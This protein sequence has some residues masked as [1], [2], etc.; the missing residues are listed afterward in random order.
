MLFGSDGNLKALRKDLKAV[1][2]NLEQVRL[3]EKQYEKIKRQYPQQKQ[4]YEKTRQ[5]LEDLEQT[6]Q[7]MEQNAIHGDTDKYKEMGKELKKY[8]GCF[9]HEFILNQ[10]DTEFY[11]TF[12]SLLRLCADFGKK[13]GKDAVILHSE[14]ENLIELVQEA[15]EKSRPNLYALSFFYLKRTDRELD[16]LS[17]EDKVDKVE[18]IYEKEFLEEMRSVL[19]KAIPM[20]R[21]NMPVLSM[22]QQNTLEERVDYIL[23]EWIWN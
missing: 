14:I 4:H 15:M 5:K 10:K 9:D 18:R 22:N 17:H 20:A 13:N 23:E 19:R 11:L 12:N 3:W 16:E 2:V 6:L 21:G 8:Q 1:G 7:T